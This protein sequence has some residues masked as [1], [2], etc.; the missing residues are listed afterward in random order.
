MPPRATS[1]NLKE[2]KFFGGN[3]KIQRLSLQIKLHK[4]QSLCYALKKLISSY[5]CFYA[6]ASYV[7]VLTSYVFSSSFRLAL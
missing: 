7:C 6:N 3:I 2:D 1:A 4:G 5:A